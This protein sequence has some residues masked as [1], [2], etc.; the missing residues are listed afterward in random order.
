MLPLDALFNGKATIPNFRIIVTSLAHLKSVQWQGILLF[1]A[2]LLF[3]KAEDPLQQE[4]IRCSEANSFPVNKEGETFFWKSPSFESLFI[5]LNSP[6]S[7]LLHIFVCLLD[8]R[9]C[10]LDSKDWRRK[11]IAKNST[12]VTWKMVACWSIQNRYNC[13]KTVSYYLCNFQYSL[14]GDL[15]LLLIFFIF[16][17]GSHGCTRVFLVFIKRCL[18]A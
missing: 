12:N 9:R 18:A 11:E 2:V 6:R 14:L 1:L 4:S 17:P 8:C 10:S 16:L 5:P 15:Q 3:T 13:K 7:C